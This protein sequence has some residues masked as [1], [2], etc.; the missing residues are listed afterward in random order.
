[1]YGQTPGS[2][3][4]LLH[5]GPS[6]DRAC[7][8]SRHTAQAGREGGLGSWLQ[9]GVPVR[10]PVVFAE[11]HGVDV[12]ADLGLVRGGEGLRRLVEVEA[13]IHEIII[14]ADDTVRPPSNCHWPATMKGWP[15]KDQ[16][17]PTT[18]TNAR[19]A[20]LQLRWAILGSNQ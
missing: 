15:S 10:R 1:M 16:P 5:R 11:A 13:L 14:V 2:P 7:H 9:H 4:A 20:H 3:G 6:Q 12:V 19:F 17:D 8:S 18:R